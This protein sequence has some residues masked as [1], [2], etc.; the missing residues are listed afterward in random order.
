MKALHI[1][2]TGLFLTAFSFAVHSQCTNCQDA[3]ITGINASGLGTSPTA[4]GHSSLAGGHTSLASGAYSFA[5]GYESKA[6][7]SS[8]IAFGSMVEANTNSS[9]VIGQ[10]LKS[11]ATGGF[12]LG[13]GY[14][15][16]DPMINNSA[17]TL[18]VG[19][20]SQYPTFFV[21]SSNGSTSTGKI[22]IGNVTNPSSKLHLLADE[23]EAAEIKLEHRSTGIRQYAQVLLGTHSIRA[24]DLENM[25]FTTPDSRNF[26]FV[27][28]NVGINTTAPTQK[29]D[30]DGNIRLRNDAAIGTWTKHSLSFNTN[31]VSR[32][33]ILSNG[34]IGIGND[35][36]VAKFQVKNGDIFI[37]DIDRGIIM[38]SP[39]GNCWRGV[40]NN[41]GQLEFVLL[42]DCNGT[43]TSVEGMDYKPGFNIVPNPASGNLQIQCT[44]EELH[45]YNAYK[46]L[47]SLGKEV[48]AGILDDISLQLD[49]QN[50]SN[51]IYFLNFYGKGAYW[52]EK[53]VVQ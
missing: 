23:H 38:K 5:F 14:G 18:M 1:I 15:W 9:V 4:T 7:G 6:I 21:S 11:T 47:D 35:D 25:V 19:F 31:K 2:L 41:L 20:N 51:G 48:K 45:N 43:T 22:G 27:N 37:E 44:V 39:D 3:T 34:N 42:P 40:L 26:A 8:S 50:L 29:L 28:G 12:L 46:M 24:G 17:S 32:M 52:T 16:N 10:F 30:V 36:P 53:V 49:I 33:V 13:A